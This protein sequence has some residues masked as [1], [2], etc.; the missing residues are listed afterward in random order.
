MKVN[1]THKNILFFGFGAVAKCVIHFLNMFF[2]YDTKKVWIVD[3]NSHTMQGE[4]IN[5]ID[6][7]HIIVMQVRAHNFD[8]LLD[9]C[10][11]KEGDLVIDLSALTSTYY[12]IA[13]C[14]K[15]GI[16]YVNTSIEDSDDKM[17]G[18]SI[19]VQQQTLIEICNKPMK[20][21]VLVECGQNPG[22]IQHYVR[23]ALN[24]LNISAGHKSD[25][26]V[27]SMRRAIT[28]HKV[29]TI[30]MS[31]ID[32][33]QSATKTEKGIIYN[34]WSVL[35]LLSEGCDKCEYVG[36]GVKN[37]YVKPQINNMDDV[38]NKL[39]G[40]DIVKFTTNNGLNTILNS[41]SPIIDEQ[42][43]VKFVEYNGRMIHHGEAFE[44]A[45]YFGDC[46]PF[47]SYV[48]KLNK[49]A[50]ESLRSCG[51]NG[52]NLE[53]YLLQNGKYVVFDKLTEQYDMYGFDS[54]GCTLYCGENTVDK[55]YWCGSIASGKKREDESDKDICS[56]FTPTIIQVAAG[57][58]S[59]M[60]YVLT[61][62]REKKLYL[63]LDLDTEYMLTNAS[64]MLGNL[65]MD[66]ISTGLHTGFMNGTDK[67]MID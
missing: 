63:P 53:M 16:D 39:V 44:L 49:Y 37:T 27:E 60:S 30:L 66:R 12:F 2:E 58:L 62:G 22:M 28:D 56:K 29:G 20:S 25:Y 32:G 9:R 18:E 13:C 19:M 48:Y 54:V 6:P 21:V 8:D 45:R 47:M 43:N 55:I 5:N 36:G 15:R 51:M 46:A 57:L 24:A 31:E 11:I 50:E 67:V 35:G 38:R 41:V 3:M 17:F 52:E 40:Y 23:Y 10:G 34:T 1:I 7:T 14:L 61:E 26:S 59:G 33:M 4:D 42:N 65:F 64:F